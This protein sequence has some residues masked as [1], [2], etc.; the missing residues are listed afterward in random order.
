MNRNNR[1]QLR[2]LTLNTPHSL[3]KLIKGKRAI[4][5]VQEIPS[6]HWKLPTC[7]EN[8]C[9]LTQSIPPSDRHS[10]YNDRPIQQN[11]YR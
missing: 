7:W 2:K 9:F 4:V 6:F 5:K 3:G 10:E 8:F 1:S 11:P